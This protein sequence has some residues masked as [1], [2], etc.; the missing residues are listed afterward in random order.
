MAKLS[1]KN[2]TVEYDKAKIS[3][4]SIR[5]D[6]AIVVVGA[7][8]ILIGIIAS[9]FISTL[10][11]IEHGLWVILL[12]LI[13]I[14]LVLVGGL[15]LIYKIHEKM[16]PIHFDLVTWLMKFK[17]NEIEVGWFNDRFV[18]ELWNGRSGWMKYS[19][20]KF[21]GCDYVLVDDSDKTKTIFMTVDLMTDTPRISITNSR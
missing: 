11:D 7:L 8:C 2:L 14:S 1:F 6:R 15:F 17:H 10:I 16:S 3:A 12:D 18:V 5:R 13:F 4:A 20:Q 21:V 9:G 19:L